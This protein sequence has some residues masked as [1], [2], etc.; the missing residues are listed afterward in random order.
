VNR[1]FRGK[2]HHNMAPIL[3]GTEAPGNVPERFFNG[4]IDEF[5]ISNISLSPE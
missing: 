2:Q 3:V 4:K 1:Q 5:V